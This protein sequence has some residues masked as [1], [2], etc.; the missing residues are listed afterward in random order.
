[1]FIYRERASTSKW[2]HTI[3]DFFNT[4]KAFIGTNYQALP[5]AFQN[6]GLAVSD[7]YCNAFLLLYIYI[8][9]AIIVFLY[10]VLSL[11]MKTTQFVIFTFRSD[12]DYIQLTLYL[13]YNFFSA[14]W[15]MTLLC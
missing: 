14:F 13:I 1:M 15:D 7:S 3:G 11:F 8:Y 4:L 9:K 10:Y 2:Y 12:V 6:S 5:Y